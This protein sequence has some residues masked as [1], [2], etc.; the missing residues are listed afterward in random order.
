MKS[1]SNEKI[2]RVN[3]RCVF[4]DL[5]KAVAQHMQGGGPL[6]TICG[7][8]LFIRN[9]FIAKRAGMHSAWLCCHPEDRAAIE[10]HFARH[11]HVALDLHFIETPP[12]DSSSLAPFVSLCKEWLNRG[13]QEAIYWPGAITFGRFCPNILEQPLPPDRGWIQG[14]GPKS[15][16][17]LLINCS[18]MDR[19]GVDLPELE[20][21]SS[22][23]QTGHLVLVPDPRLLLNDEDA[24]QAERDLL[25]SLRKQADGV[26]AK[27]DRYI[28]LAISR[29]LMRFPIRP[30]WITL[31]AGLVGICCGLIAAQGGYVFLLIGALGFQLNSILDGIDGEIARAK[32]Y[33]SKLGAWLDTLADDSSNIAFTVGLSVGCYR[34]W[35]NPIYLALG[36]ITGVGFLITAILMYHYL[37]TV[38]HSGDLNDFKM[39][40]E[41]SKTNMANAVSPAEILDS[42]R[43]STV[44]A[45]LKFIVRR[46]VFVFLSTVFAL[47]GQL[48]VMA[49]FFAIG[50]TAVWIAILGYRIVLPRIRPHLRHEQI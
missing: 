38:A 39:P 28:S 14:I 43:V 47:I 35:E 27:F 34:T 15:H 48:R 22:S 20:R 30:N 13:I 12:A 33:E 46:D 44:L 18:L 1:N 21:P 29:Q 7:L 6:K 8:P 50:A 3:T 45:K 10:R 25:F 11:R 26:V 32:L 41:E 16:P 9:L 40:W 24:K 2:I 31:V 23:D 42:S 4:F 37:I 49:W 17:M 36:A 19:T 5:R